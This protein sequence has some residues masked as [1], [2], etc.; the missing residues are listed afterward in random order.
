MDWR[1][2]ELARLAG[3]SGRP[4]FILAHLLVPHEPYIYGAGCQH[5]IPYWP[6]H[7]WSDSVRVRQGYLDQIQCVNT[8]VLEAV[9]SIQARSRTPPVI[10]IQADH[11]HGRLGR[12][13]PP[14]SAVKPESVLERVSIFA[15]Y[16]LPTVPPAEVPDDISPVNTARLLLRHY[17][18][19]DMPPLPEVTYWSA[20][21]SPYHFER[22]QV[23]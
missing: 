2:R 20:T 23:Q 4:Q 15:A 19:A 3:S 8:K 12:E 22:V 10:L 16:S 14:L 5:R 11:G 7:D 13:I 1:F 18:L 21:N 6:E 9:D 17:F